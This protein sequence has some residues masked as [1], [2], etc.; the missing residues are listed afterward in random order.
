MTL[1]EMMKEVATLRLSVKP[2]AQ[3]I[4]VAVGGRSLYKLHDYE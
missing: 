1:M 4:G 2:E 3:P